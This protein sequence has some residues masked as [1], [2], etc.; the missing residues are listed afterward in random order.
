MRT[1]VK[2]FI[3]TFTFYLVLWIIF[4]KCHGICCTSIKYVKYWGEARQK[5]KKSRRRK[6]WR[7]KKWRRRRISRRKKSMKRR[8]RKMRRIRVIR[9]IKNKDEEKENRKG[10]CLTLYQQSI[11]PWGLDC[12]VSQ[13]YRNL[14]IFHKKYL[15]ANIVL[16]KTLYMWKVSGWESVDKWC[17]P[18]RVALLTDLI[19][20]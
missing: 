17:H 1:F 12:F 15:T 5:K 13:K 4:R 6:R 9:K 11:I 18:G 8:R 10:T 7:R 20:C 19:L 14:W 3:I 2:K 16:L